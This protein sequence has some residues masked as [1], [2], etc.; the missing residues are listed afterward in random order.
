MTKNAML[1]PLAG[2]IAVAAALTFGARTALAN[3]SAMTCWNPP[4]T[5]GY[6]TEPGFDCQNECDAWNGEG[7]TTGVC[8]PEESGG[9]QCC[10]CFQ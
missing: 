2:A 4:A 5:V 7:T 10:N 8:V 6:C 3:D 9:Q 1:V